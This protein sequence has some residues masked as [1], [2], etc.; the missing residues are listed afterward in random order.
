VSKR[1]IL[2]LSEVGVLTVASETTFESE[3]RLHSAIA[4][5]PEVLP[6]EDIG[7]GPLVTIANELDLGHGPM[8]TLAV[9]A[10][11][12]LAIIEFKRGS[13][14]PDV[15]KVVAQ[16]L[17]YGSALWR[18]SY[19]SMEQAARVCSPGFGGSLIDHVGDRLGT[20]GT[21]TFDPDAFRRGVESGLDSGEFVFLYVAR[22]LDDRTKRIMTYL[23]EGPRM[24]FFAVEVDYFRGPDGGAV[25]VPRVAFVPSW[26]TD[27]QRTTT[28]R[29]ELSLE[30]APADVRAIAE[31]MDAVASRIG[32]LA[33][34]ARASLIY[35]PALG[36]PG[37]TVYLDGSKVEF[38]LD[39]FRRR[40][41]DDFA[42]DF[43]TRLEGFV[44]KPIRRGTYPGIPP[45]VVLAQWD[46]AERD[47]VEHYFTARLRHV[48]DDGEPR[49]LDV[50]R[51]HSLLEQLPE[52]RWTTYGDL[53]SAIRSHPRAVGGHIGNCPSCENAWRVLQVGGVVSPSFRWTDPNR[54]DAPREVLEKEGVRFVDSHAAEG[55]RLS[56]EELAALG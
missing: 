46:A 14:N 4:E 7:L 48:E 2:Q 29:P 49:V 41:E 3:E 24:T 56:P 27:P 37:M 42:D 22:D 18:L 10:S 16:V 6:S 44:G 45:S 13:E 51:L 17:D 20:L 35:R 5:H 26:V 28:A 12:R 1:R 31:R 9:D 11:G 52:G 43:L 32:V 38:D 53:A 39:S 40:R 36:A 47:L 25:L 33:T 15:R 50:D 8:D 21:E 54:L 34:R 19:E 30:E 23:A 55:D